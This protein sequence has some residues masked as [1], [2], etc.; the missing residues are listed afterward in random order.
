MEKPSSN[1]MNAPR[2]NSG[3]IADL[4]LPRLASGDGEA[5]EELTAR[6][7]GLVWSL[8]RQQSPT[9]AEAEDAVQD[10]FLSIWQSAGRFDPTVASETTFIAMIAR[11]RLIDR[12]RKR[13]R[14]PENAVDP[15]QFGALV[16]PLGESPGRREALDLPEEAAQAGKA[17]LLLSENQ[18]KVLRLSIQQGLSHEQIAKVTSMPLGT[19]KT[20]AR[21]G[22]I[23]LREIM[24]DSSSA[25]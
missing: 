20:H 19:V 22:L 3:T 2:S 21:R 13:S 16:S 17:F 10:I 24:Q 5:A 7:G 4:I 25:T 11:R 1:K 8:A 15:Q 14:R 9:A 23:R 6:Y 18:Q 12:Q